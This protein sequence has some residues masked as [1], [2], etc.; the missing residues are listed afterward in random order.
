MKITMIVKKIM[1]SSSD[2]CGPPAEHVFG[3]TRRGEIHRRWNCGKI[4]EKTSLFQG[5]RS[6]SSMMLLMRPS[7]N[8]C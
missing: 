5:V 4:W 3:G 7:F 1:P 2:T 6:R 8:Q